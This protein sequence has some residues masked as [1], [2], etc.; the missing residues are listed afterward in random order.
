[1]SFTRKDGL[2]Y[3]DKAIDVYREAVRLNPKWSEY[4][5]KL[6]RPF[7][8]MEKVWGRAGELKEAVRLSGR[9]YFTTPTA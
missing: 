9:R 1:L 5:V 8:K 7:C 3:I 6:G 4:K 2:S